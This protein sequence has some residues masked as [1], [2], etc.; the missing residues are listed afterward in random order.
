MRLTSV[1]WD[2]LRPALEPITSDPLEADWAAMG[3][4]QDWGLGLNPILNMAESMEDRGVKAV[5]LPEPELLTDS[6]R[7]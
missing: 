5:S 7:T 2:S 1:N 6:L 4:R 3:L